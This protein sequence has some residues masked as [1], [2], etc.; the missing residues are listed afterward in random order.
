MSVSTKSDLWANWCER[1]GVHRRRGWQHGP[2]PGICPCR[3]LQANSKPCLCRR[4]RWADWGGARW[5]DHT[6]TFFRA[7]RAAIVTTEPYELPEIA[8]AATWLAGLGVVAFQH[9][10]DESPYFPGRT[11]LIAVVPAAEADAYQALEPTAIR[12]RE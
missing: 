7:G 11:H 2:K 1:H 9:P 3:L 4:R 10:P 8:D 12:W 5:I 6:E